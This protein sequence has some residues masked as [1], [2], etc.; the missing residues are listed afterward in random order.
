M[1]FSGLFAYGAVAAGL[2]PVISIRGVS[3]YLAALQ[4]EKDKDT[5]TAALEAPTFAAMAPTC[6]RII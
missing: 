6:L 4:V 2:E 1:F 3:A 5:K